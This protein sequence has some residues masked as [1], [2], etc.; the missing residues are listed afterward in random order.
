M[1]DQMGGSGRPPNPPT[2]GTPRRSRRAPRRRVSTAA[3]WAVRLGLFV[4]CAFPLYWMLVSSF[5][6]SHELLASPPT[7]WPHVGYAR[8]EPT[9][10]ND[11][12]A[13]ARIA[14]ATCSVDNTVIDETY[15]T[16][17]KRRISS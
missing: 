17:Q 5:K 2:L 12:A 10:R 14:W 4:F 9:P 13:S 8:P 7:F 11:N 1:P 15:G 6:V 16:P 3:A